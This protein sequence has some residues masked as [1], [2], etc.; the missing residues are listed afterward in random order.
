MKLKLLTTLVFLLFATSVFA[1]TTADSQRERFANK[2]KSLKQKDFIEITGKLNKR[3]PDNTNITKSL[4]KNRAQVAKEYE[5]QL[6][7]AKLEL[8]ENSSFPAE[9]EELQ[10]VLITWNYYSF[11]K[12]EVIDD[13]IE[14]LF[15]GKG[16]YYNQTTQMPELIDIVSVPDVYDESP[17]SLIFVELADAIQQEVPV[18]INIWN[19]EDSTMIKEFMASKGKPLT[20]YRFFVNPG[21]SFWYRDCGPVAFYYG[22]QDE[23]A[24]LDFEYYGGRPMDDEIPAKVAAQAGFP[25][26][27][28]TIEFEGGNILV[29]GDGTLFTT[30]AVADL[31]ADSEGKYYLDPTSP[32]GFNI[33]TKKPLLLNQLK[34]SLMNVMNLT[35]LKILPALANDG[36]TGHIDLYADFYDENNFVF[37]KYPTAMANFADYRTVGKNIDT[38]LSL[39]SRNEKYYYKRT[40]PFP[41]RDDGSW[42]PSANNYERYTRTYSNHLTLNKTIIQ[43]IFY[44]ES[45]GDRTGDLASIEEIKA[46][47]PGYKIAPI[48]IR[49]FDGFGGAIH[50]ITK[51]IPAENPLRIFH[52]IVQKGDQIG[53]K[54]PVLAEITNKSGIKKADLNW[55]VKGETEWNK[56]TMVNSELDNFVSDIPAEDNVESKIIEYYISAESNNGKTMTKPITAPDGFYSFE[57]G[58]NT[59]VE[60]LNGGIG[61]FY[62]NPAN[63]LSSIEVNSLSSGSMTVYVLNNEG[64][65]VYKN[66]FELANGYDLLSIETSRLP[67]GAYIVNIVLPDSKSISKKL[68]IVR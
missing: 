8:P 36:G 15:E 30:S 40:I 10:A 50:C 55:R 7:P 28:T 45:T 39:R 56:S 66:S 49:A 64:K 25:V 11:D 5:K 47:Y 44:N 13:Y 2:L 61:E 35:R 53:N 41:R 27:S 31:N 67:V 23:V 21:N 4:E 14:P 48:D 46:A 26:Y 19:A 37:S 54:F 62:P 63:E 65:E 9:F 24:F 18:W 51:Q 3:V 57:Y 1:E 22:D 16:I 29:D 42:Y 33:Q 52:Y 17:Y 20:N 32:Y 68:N 58:T 38:L 6:S 60:D 43:P 59:S 34:D 12:N